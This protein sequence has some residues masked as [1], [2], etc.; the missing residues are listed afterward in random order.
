MHFNTRTSITTITN[1]QAPT[2]R[3]KTFRGAF[4]ASAS[5]TPTES[6]SDADD[7]GSGLS[8]CMP[9]LSMVIND[10]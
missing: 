6:G 4:A 1:P 8:M 7:D 10:F 3:R 9:C 2:V 5:A